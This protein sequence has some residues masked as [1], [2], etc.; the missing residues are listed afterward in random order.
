[1]N[2]F[3]SLLP[4]L[5]LSGISSWPTG[6]LRAEQKSDPNRPN[7]IYILADDLGYGE[8]GSYGQKKIQTPH[9]DDLA[10]RGMKF[11]QHYSGSAVCACSRCVVLT[12]KHTGHA[13]IRSNHEVG[14]WGPDEPEG[15]LPLIDEEITIAELLK[16]R[17]YQTAAIGKW[18]LGGPG[19][20]GH[21]CYQGFD[22]FYGYLCQRVAH[23]YYPTHLWNN[24]DVDVLGNPYFNAHQKID[25]VPKD[26]EQW[27]QYT[28]SVY[29]TDK[30]ID[31]ALQFIEENEDRPFF[32]YYATPI[33]HVAIQVPADSLKPY[34][35]QFEEQPYLGQKSYLP[36]PTPRAA[37]AGMISRM[38][39]NIGRLI[40]KIHEL[41]LDDNTLIIFSSDNGPT[42]NGGSDSQFFESAGPLRGLKVSLH[43][44]GIRVPMI[45]CWPGKIEADTTTDLISG[46]QDILPTI[47]ELGGA[48][49]PEDVDGVSLVPTLFNRG[50]QVQH[51][52]LYWELRNQQSVRAGDWK[53]YR[54]A[55]KKGDIKTELYN[56]QTD[57]GEANNLA[58]SEPEQLKKMLDIARSA[59]VPSKE[60]P[61]PYDG[62]HS[63]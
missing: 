31:H 16:D 36:H 58:E 41:E 23:N 30:M 26:A 18:G 52:H 17:G 50:K 28:G 56:L 34:L 51:D 7:L 15:Q 22:K 35:G 24:H 49:T 12:G 54:S 57:L 38:D 2:R 37:Y 3:L 4:L 63:N 5:L 32:L 33:P 13:Y 45:A 53:L 29:A 47:T 21:P 20:S 14:G 10:R 27:K 59:R 46:F 48:Q 1:M 44:G 19:S 25:S 40:A 61:S 60:F 42:F 55:N 6:E 62:E 43:E 8:L 39:R 9:L 11:T